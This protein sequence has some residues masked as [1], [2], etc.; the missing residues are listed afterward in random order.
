M[1][2]AIE[3]LNH[4]ANVLRGVV[5]LAQS[6]TDL[7][8][9][10][11]LSES[12]RYAAIFS[13]ALG[14]GLSLYE[15]SAYARHAPALEH[16]SIKFMAEIECMIEFAVRGAM[17]LDK[18]SRSNHQLTDADFFNFCKTELAPISMDI[19]RLAVEASMQEEKYYL[20]MTPEE[21]ANHQ[22]P[23]FDTDG[24]S[25]YV[26]GY[27]PVDEEE[28]KETL[29]VQS[30]IDTLLTATSCA[31]EWNFGTSLSNPFSTRLDTRDL[32]VPPPPAPAPERPISLPQRPYIVSERYQKLLAKKSK[33]DPSDFLSLT[34][35]SKD[36]LR[37]PVLKKYTC[38]ITGL[39]TR[40]PVQDPTSQEKIIYD[41]INILKHLDDQRQNQRPATSF[42]T[43]FSLDENQLIGM[44]NEQT[45]INVRLK[46]LQKRILASDTSP[47]LKGLPL[48][49]GQQK[50]VELARKEVGADLFDKEDF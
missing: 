16:Q 41:E 4:G 48:E 17:V 31:L 11:E 28:C 36:F 24:D 45:I 6:S 3:L 32:P 37:D 43:G 10:K 40:Y 5:R 27:R 2:S 1:T 38:S 21:R 35:L 39:P 19:I 34:S 47:D 44:S 7:F 30:K 14:V 22:R 33:E 8:Q 50:F 12:T 18:K 29:R 26:V 23:I 46:S 49:P 20:E 9:D 13:K 25:I 15:T 42:K